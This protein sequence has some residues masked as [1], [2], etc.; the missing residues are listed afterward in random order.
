[1]RKYQ[2]TGSEGHATGLNH[3]RPMIMNVANDP[4][5]PCPLGL[6]YVR[7]IETFEGSIAPIVVLLEKSGVFWVC[8]DGCLI[9]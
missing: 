3:L 1:M 5:P 7:K 6:S 8:D 4:D 9:F 2:S